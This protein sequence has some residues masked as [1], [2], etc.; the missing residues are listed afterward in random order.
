MPGI[1]VM[2]VSKVCRDGLKKVPSGGV[3]IAVANADKEDRC[4]IPNAQREFAGLGVFVRV[5]SDQRGL[6]FVLFRANICHRG[7]LQQM[8]LG[9]LRV[10]LPALATIDGLIVTISLPALYHIEE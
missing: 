7:K 10:M 5:R 4:R 2:N 3:D 9:C 8:Q 6:F 1:L